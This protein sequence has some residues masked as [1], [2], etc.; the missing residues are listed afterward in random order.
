MM[1]EGNNHMAGVEWSGMNGVGWVRDGF[2]YV[3]VCV[4]D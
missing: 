1:S 3:G 2:T 4:P